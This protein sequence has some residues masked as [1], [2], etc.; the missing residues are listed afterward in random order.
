M[1]SSGCHEAAETRTIRFKNTFSNEMAPQPH[2]ERLPS[3]P[4][5]FS[6]WW[7]RMRPKRDG[8]DVAC[9]YFYEFLHTLRHLGSQP[10]SRDRPAVL[11]EVGD[12]DLRE[13]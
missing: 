8:G 11:S 4:F 3:W 6:L 9:T 1:Q 12:R 7:S 13:V 2:P 5:N 10:R